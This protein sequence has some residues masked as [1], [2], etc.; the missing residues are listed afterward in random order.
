MAVTGPDL[1]AYVRGNASDAAFAVSCTAEAAALV[2]RY[3]GT[4]AVPDAILDRAVLEVGAELFHRRSAPNG[5]QQFGTVEGAP[6]VR[7]NR[8]PM[9]AGYPILRP[10]VGVGLA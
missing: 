1:L 7:V 8:D 9:V 3:V 10:F 4:R 6:V 2:E 5:V